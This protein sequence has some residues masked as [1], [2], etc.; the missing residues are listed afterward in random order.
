VQLHQHHACNGTIY[1][2][3]RGG[4]YLPD[5]RFIA[6]VRYAAATDRDIF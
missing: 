6:D 4:P 5:D 2:V 3:H 1:R